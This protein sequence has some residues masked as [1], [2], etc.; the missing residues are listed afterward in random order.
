MARD[1]IRKVL[2]NDVGKVN[3]RGENFIDKASETAQGKKCLTDLLLWLLHKSFASKWNS[4][5]ATV[6]GSSASISDSGAFPLEDLFNELWRSPFLGWFIGSRRP[7]TADEVPMLIQGRNVES[8]AWGPTMQHVAQLRRCRGLCT[9]CKRV[10]ISW[11]LADQEFFLLSRANHQDFNLESCLVLDY[12]F[13]PPIIELLSVI[14]SFCSLELRF[15]W[16]PRNFGDGE[17][18]KYWIRTSTNDNQ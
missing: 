11:N 2:L 3:G 15:A 5:I 18:S 14:R 6:S 13:P 4:E 1:S 16:L 9:L 7:P 8:F 17:P 10:S 12:F